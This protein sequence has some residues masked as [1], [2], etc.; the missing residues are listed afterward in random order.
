MTRDI[1]QLGQTVRARRIEVGM[2][3]TELARRTGVTASTITRLEAGE[4]AAPRAETIRNVALALGLP[5]TDL[6]ANADYLDPGDLPSIT[7]YLRTRYG[8]LSDSAQAEIAR[9]FRDITARY[10]YDADRHGPDTG[11]DET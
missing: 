9:S 5:I 3:A 10:G 8:Y 2:S 11:E 6:L 4:S 7:P 1:H